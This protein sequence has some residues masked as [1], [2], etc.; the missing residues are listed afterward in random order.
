MTPDEFEGSIVRWAR[1]QSD[2]SALVLIGSRALNAGVDALSDWDFYIISDRPGRYH[3]PGWVSEIAPPWCAHV[4]RSPRGAV[5]V[6]AVFAGGLEADFVPL[7]AWRM[8]LVCWCMRHPEWAAGMP[9]GLRHGITETRV[10]LL[11]SAHRV[12]VGGAPWEN[13]LSALAVAWPSRRMSAAEL[14]RHAAA[15]WQKAVWVTKK[16]ARP[17]PRAALHWLHKLIVE[18]VYALLEEEA[19]L[20][21]RR[22]RPEAQKAEKWLEPRRL[23]QTELITSLDPKVLARALLAQ[24]GLFEEVSRSVAASHGFALPDH[25]AVAAWLRTELARILERA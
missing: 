4:E 2:I 23:E 11:N 6:S 13:R 18:H 3:H 24:M 19:W 9:A 14:N 1:R 15:F 16:I 12:L 25:A 7:A 22:A 17:E 20:A 5:K 21:G 10:I 8:K